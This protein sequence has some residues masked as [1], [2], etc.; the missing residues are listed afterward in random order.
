M[1]RGS[2][3]SIAK[4][5]KKI[6]IWKYVYIFWD[7]QKV[8]QSTFAISVIYCYIAFYGKI[9]V[10]KLQPLRFTFFKKKVL[11]GLINPY[12]SHDRKSAKYCTYNPFAELF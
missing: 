7:M 6:E 2:N 1:K 12:I 9:V 10:I 8:C 5:I 3:F 11:R 4:L